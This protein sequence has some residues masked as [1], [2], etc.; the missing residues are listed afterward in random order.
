MAYGRKSQTRGRYNPKY[1][2]AA[3]VRGAFKNKAVRAV[4]KK[5]PVKKA[6][7]NKKAIHVLA[8][9]LKRVQFDAKFGA[10]QF[11]R[12]WT[13]LQPAV[14]GIN[15]CSN[16]TPLFFMANSFYADGN[17]PGGG[18][19]I[20]QGSVNA[21]THIPQMSTDSSTMNFIKRINDSNVLLD[22]YNFGAQ[23]DTRTLVSK[24]Q[25]LPIQANYTFNFSG[26]TMKPG[27]PAVRFRVTFF[28]LRYQQIASS[29]KD[30]TLPGAGGALWHMCEDDSML[31]NYFSKVHHQIVA[32][33][34]LLIR[35]PKGTVTTNPDG[36]TSPNEIKLEDRSL[37]FRLK[38][39]PKPLTPMFG[40]STLPEQPWT[41]IPVQ[42]QLW[43][44]ISTNLPR[45]SSL[46]PDIEINRALYWRDRHDFLAP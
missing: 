7:K 17:P 38:F 1:R 10:I 8:R 44:L 11:Q 34:F 32:D 14:S 29:A 30:F 25:Y 18:T 6:A 12:Q 45:N 22:Q 35:S 40:G 39:P 31:R 24:D 42:D 3:A 41:N 33:K 15:R 27:F 23:N 19:K 37:R 5:R 20:Y 43:C 46:V 13:S 2:R 36:S 9:Q 16:T 4:Y 26:I 21:T 28:K